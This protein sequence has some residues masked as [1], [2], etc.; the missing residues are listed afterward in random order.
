MKPIRSLSACGVVIFLMLNLT[1]CG[2]KAPPLPPLPVT[3]QQSDVATP[4]PSPSPS[5]GTGK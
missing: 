5:E 3:P 2:V 1:S 4:A